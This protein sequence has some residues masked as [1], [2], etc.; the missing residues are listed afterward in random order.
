MELEK[1]LAT[2]QSELKAHFDKAKDQEKQFG[3]VLDETKATIAKLQTQLDA[4]DAK[5][6]ERETNHPEHKTLADN[7]KENDSVQ[8]LMRDKTGRAVI[9]LDGKMVADLME[10]KTTI[11]SGTSGTVGTATSGVLQIDRRPGIT[12]EARGAIV[13]R[14][15]FA[16]RPTNLAVV[17]YV[18]VNA[19]F[20]NA[21]PQ[22]EGSA[23]YENAV[24]FTTDSERIRT[25]ATWIPATRQIL[26]DWSELQGFLVS[27]LPYYV[28][29]EEQEQLISGDDSGENLK[30]ITVCAQSFDT[31]LLN[32]TAGYNR[33]D[34][35]G[36]AIEQIASD[37]E[38]APSWALVH[39]HD[40]WSMRLTKDSYG[41]YLLGDPQT[42]AP[43]NI[44]G[45]RVVPCVSM[46][47]GYFVV[48][49]GDPA[50][51]EIR[52]RMGMQVEISTEHSDYFTKNLVAIRAEKRMTLIVYRGAAFVYG[53]FSMSPD[54]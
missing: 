29:L 2:L 20:A 14:D 9:T 27:S 38:V 16:Q 24:T 18:K 5:L 40:L 37:K 10:R 42:A 43:F 45:L 41:R 32:A 25:I 31:S 51:A 33:I 22:T 46:T 52:D 4:V 47:S 30:G 44:F 48:G 39:P 12:E 15:L 23:K 17:D 1:Q 50:C 36:R 6:V 49:N 28:N 21:S 54:N 3:T 11:T 19:G 8:R 13:V 35:L 7:L 26:D 34:C 53:A